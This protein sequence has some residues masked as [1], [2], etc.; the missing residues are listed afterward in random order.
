MTLALERAALQFQSPSMTVDVALSGDTYTLRRDIGE[1]SYWAVDLLGET[2][3]GKY[4]RSLASHRIEGSISSTL[5]VTGSAWER[6]LTVYPSGGTQTFLGTRQHGYEEDTAI[7][8]TVDGV[9]VTPTGT[10]TSGRIAVITR[11]SNITHP[12]LGSTVIGS[13]TTTYTMTRQGLDVEW[14]ITWAT[15]LV[16]GQCYGAMFPVSS[17]LDTGKTTSG[18]KATLTANDDSMVSSSQ[19][20]TVW[21]WSA[22]GNV[23][24]CMALL[25]L[26]TVAN[27]GY[28]DS[29]NMW[30]QDRS[31]GSTNKAYAGFTG[32][33]IAAGDVWTGHVLY[34]ADHFSATAA[35]TLDF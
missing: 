16:G 34:M 21:F 33:N 26:A 2:V 1:S 35:T 7:T 14:S 3:G 29:K 10:P 8:V 30:I 15:A 12:D 5:G 6:A 32:R 28:A 19:S 18:S 24:A 4:V 25:D 22:S 13:A 11:T 9:T 17:T 27:W 31:G 23:G 20:K